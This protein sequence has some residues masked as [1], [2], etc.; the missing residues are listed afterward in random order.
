MAVAAFN[1]HR[2]AS[3]AHLGEVLLIDVTHHSYHDSRSELGRT[4]IR[5]EID[6]LRLRILGVAEDTLHAQILAI[7]RHQPDKLRVRRIFRK[8]LKVA[9]PQSLSA[10]RVAHV[11]LGVS[12]T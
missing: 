2:I 10:K 12:S 5:G 9:R 4:L 3:I 1:R 8:H 11:N 6:L 7:V